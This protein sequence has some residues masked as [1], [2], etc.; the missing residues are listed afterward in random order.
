M[1]QAIDEA[2]H[3]IDAYGL[4]M[5]LDDALTESNAELENARLNQ[6]WPC[7]HQ[8]QGRMHGLMTVRRWI[9]TS[10]PHL[11]SSRFTNINQH[12]IEKWTNPDES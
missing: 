8:A 2:N 3:T 6:N 12:H 5:R 4:L 7:L 10:L 9:T 11:H 1:K